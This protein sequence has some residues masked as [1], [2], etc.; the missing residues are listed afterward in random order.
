MEDQV[1]QN[2]KNFSSSTKMSE[3]KNLDKKSQAR[4]SDRATER[5]VDS[6]RSGA[7]EQAG[8]SRKGDVAKRDI[9]S[10]K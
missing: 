5:S 9:G 7:R 1:V 2:K 8:Q 4:T 10:R 3:G 6:T